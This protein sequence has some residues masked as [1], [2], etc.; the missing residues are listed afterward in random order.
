M[1]YEI[2]IILASAFASALLTLGVL[3]YSLS[4]HTKFPVFKTSFRMMFFSYCSLG[5]LIVL[6]TVRE[7]FARKRRRTDISD[8]YTYFFRIAGFY[9]HFYMD[10]ADSPGLCYT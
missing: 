4:C 2:N 10:V 1:I 9:V 7:L 6:E 3:F 8:D 5:L